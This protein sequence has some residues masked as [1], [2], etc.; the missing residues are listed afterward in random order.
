MATSRNP[1]D[2]SHEWKFA[3]RT[4]VVRRAAGVV[5]RR[6]AEMT[7]FFAAAPVGLVARMGGLVAKPLSAERGARAVSPDCNV[8]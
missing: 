5:G 1:V 2:S 3:A 4:E 6:R 7:E 8:R